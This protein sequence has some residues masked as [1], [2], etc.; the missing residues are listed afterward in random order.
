[1]R[2]LLLA[3]LLASAGALAEAPD[4]GSL[5]AERVKKAV[6]AV[7]AT[8][9]NINW[10]N[11]WKRLSPHTAE[12][13]GLIAEGHTILVPA[14]E[15]VGFTLIEVQRL[16]EQDWVPAKVKLIDYDIP[17]ALLEVEDANFWKG[18]EPLP[19]AATV[20]TS[21]EVQLARWVSGKFETS[22][23][24]VARLESDT[25]SY[26]RV[27]SLALH[28]AA[29]GASSV[30]GE[31]VIAGGQLIGMVMGASKDGMVAMASPFLADFRRDAA[32]PASYRGF[33]R[34]GLYWQNLTNPSLRA[35]L[36]LNPDDGGILV[37][38]V[39]PQGG[40]AQ[41]LQPRD[42]VL[43]VAGHKLDA[44]GRFEHAKYGPTRWSILLTEGKR[45]GDVIDMLVLRDGKR[46]HVSVPLK[47]W[48]TQEDRIPH[49][50]AGQKPDFVV[51]G[52]LV[53]QELSAPYLQSFPNW[54]LASPPRLLV[55]YE[56]DAD[57]P[58]SEHPKTVVLTVVLPDPANLGYQE[59]HD[60]I[61]DSVNGVLL[62]RLDDLRD[63][64]K[65]PVG[66]NHII[67]FHPGQGVRRIVL[68][69]SEVE[70]A[71]TRVQLD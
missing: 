16:G 4:A 29:T 38:R 15:L 44:S 55:A 48:S 39:L 67:E 62:R 40:G 32:N 18:L 11:P 22:G 45:A 43:E 42:I 2:L 12:F 49:N 5:P 63:A 70:A 27:H 13:N 33:A 56:L 24:T 64:L 54:R 25:F 8:D 26:G 53:F 47:R 58:T 52:G 23:A 59:L 36:G 60:L 51:A 7:R 20:P 19:F 31:A 37:M 61:V 10:K 3:A 14:T 57:W 34:L 69:A 6:V 50:M 9:Q 17:L 66:P 28:L 41:V 46:Q 65:K 1:V 71:T 35:Y 21:G 30:Q 68:D